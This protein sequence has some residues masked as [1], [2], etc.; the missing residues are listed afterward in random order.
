MRGRWNT[1]LLSA[2]ALGA[3]ACSL[4]AAAAPTH[5]AVVYPEVGEPYRSVFARIIDGIEAKTGAPVTRY[6]LGTQFNADTLQNDLR[7]QDTRVVITLGRT[8]LKAS[9]ELER[10]IKVVAG[11]VVVVLESE[12]RGVPVHSLTPDPAL[13]FARL[14]SLAP[15]I[16]RVFVV[17]SAPQ[18]GWLI[19]LAHDAAKQHGLELVAR[20][21]ADISA[22]MPLYQELLARADAKTDALWLPQDS[23][24]VHETL[25]LPLVLRTAWSRRLAVFS[26]NVSHVKLGVLF[27]LYPDNFE[28]GRRLAS[29][30][31]SA[32]SGSAPAGIVPSKEMLAALNVGT[33][34]HLELGMSYRQLQA[35]DLVVPE[36]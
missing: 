7:R 34:N 5:I 36:R 21:A 3:L 35:F 32:T 30:A 13:L 9:G 20:E 19:R 24:T 18:N 15:H 25:V 14:K 23:A 11:G 12:A 2:L 31:L 27:S 1:R 4:V 22:A 16:K 17:Y 26:S 8:G 29:A 10:D 33:A 28:V 6:A